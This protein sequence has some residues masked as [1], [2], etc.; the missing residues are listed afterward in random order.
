MTPPPAPA[1]VHVPPLPAELRDERG[2]P[3]RVDGRGTPSAPP[4]RL[5]VAGGPWEPV[6]AWAGPWPLEE[7][8]WDPQRRTR[9]A[10]WQVRTAAGVAYLVAL[11]RGRCLVEATYD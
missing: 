1:L 3:V 6:V 4:A 8:W 5:A 2:A 9:R 11:E 7:R 10:R